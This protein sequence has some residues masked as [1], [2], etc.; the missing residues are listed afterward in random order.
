MSV[1]PSSVAASVSCCLSVNAMLAASWPHRDAAGCEM[2]PNCETQFGGGSAGCLLAN[3][4]SADPSKRVLLVEA[5]PLQ[6]RYERVPEKP[7]LLI[8]TQIP[9]FAPLLIGSDMDWKYSTERQQNACLAMVG[10]K[11]PWA[12]AKGLGGSSSIN[13]MLYVRGNRRDYDIWRNEY[14]TEGWAYNDV[15]PHFKSIERS[16]VPDHDGPLMNWSA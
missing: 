3:R 13:F 11:C 15:L 14:G 7:W 2:F 10:Q 4:L 6:K 5:G 16:M 9:L 8:D 1:H 12:R